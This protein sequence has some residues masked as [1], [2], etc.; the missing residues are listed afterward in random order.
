MQCRRNIRKQS[1]TQGGASLVAPCVWRMPEKSL[2][3][4]GVPPRPSSQLPSVC[5]HL[6]VTSALFPA[7][8]PRN[9]LPT[10]NITFE[11]FRHAELL[12]HEQDLS[13][14]VHSVRDNVSDHPTAST[15]V[16]IDLCTDFLT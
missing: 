3:T 15:S 8:T 6:A 2:W 9:R 5:N 10:Q 11:N 16:P 4:R 13:A 12:Q 7:P 14:V 1:Q